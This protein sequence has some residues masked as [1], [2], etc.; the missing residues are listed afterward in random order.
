MKYRRFAGMLVAERAPVERVCR[1]CDWSNSDGGPR[2]Y[3]HSNTPCCHC[4]RNLFARPR[5]GDYWRIKR[6][7]IDAG[8]PLPEVPASC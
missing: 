6:R 5:T 7:P 8:V 3:A 2:V 1:T 4:S